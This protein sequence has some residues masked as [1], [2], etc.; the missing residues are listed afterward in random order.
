MLHD[1]DRQPYGVWLEVLGPRESPFL[2]TYSYQEA[3]ASLPDHVRPATPFEGI[4]ADMTRILAKNFVSLPGGEYKM[5]GILTGGSTRFRTLYLDSYLGR[6]RVSHI[7]LAEMDYL[8][9]MLVA[10][11]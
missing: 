10:H 11:K 5:P 9:G 1:P 2:N 8:V 4:S 6:P 7:R 3:M